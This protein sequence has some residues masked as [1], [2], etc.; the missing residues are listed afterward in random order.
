[1]LRRGDAAIRS[2]HSGPTFA[3]CTGDQ[4][5]ATASLPYDA[6]CPQVHAFSHMGVYNF[7]PSAPIAYSAARVA[8][9][10]GG[11][12]LD[13]ELWDPGEGSTALQV[14]D[15][16]D[17]PVD[18]TWEVRCYDGT[19]AP[20]S[21]G[22]YAPR[23][24]WSGASGDVIQASGPYYGTTVP[25]ALDLW[26]WV[27]GGS[28]NNPQPG[29]NRSSLSKYS[30]RLVVLHVPIPADVQGSFGDKR[31]YKIKYYIGSSSTDR[32]TWGVTVKGAPIRL[33]PNP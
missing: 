19:A 29:P 31:W 5:E 13:L 32:T 15:P 1:M 25:K 30:D 2:A 11:G 3:V 4:A 21:D 22:T 24:G 23:G 16:N 18:F 10:L 28:A 20:G 26:G 6:A 7:L 14:L 9:E 17:Q 12:Q 33:I 8:P 27:V